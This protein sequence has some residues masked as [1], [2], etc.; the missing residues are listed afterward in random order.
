MQ[1]R[2]SPGSTSPPHPQMGP[3]SSPEVP[4]GPSSFPGRRGSA[5]RCRSSRLLHVWGSVPRVAPSPALQLVRE[6]LSVALARSLVCWIS[7]CCTVEILWVDSAQHCMGLT[8]HTLHSL[9]R[10]CLL[11]TIPTETQTALGIDSWVM[12]CCRRGL[13]VVRLRSNS[14]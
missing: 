9:D 8:S 6:H 11:F 5:V 12:E 14:G 2:V 4:D 1:Q 13:E 3:H 7:A 10:E